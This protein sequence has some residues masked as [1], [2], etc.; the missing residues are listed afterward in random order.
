MAVAD[1]MAVANYMVDNDSSQD[2]HQAILIA[3]LL[4]ASHKSQYG[5]LMNGQQTGEYKVP[6]LIF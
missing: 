3:V 4:N 5:V 6:V 1:D 2:G